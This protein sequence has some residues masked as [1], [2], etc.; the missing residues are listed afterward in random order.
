[1]ARVVPLTEQ[2]EAELPFMLAE[3]QAFVAAWPLTGAAIHQSDSTL[4]C[5]R[6]GLGGSKFLQLDTPPS[7]RRAKKICITVWPKLKVGF[8][9]FRWY[10]C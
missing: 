7:S 8:P 5:R 4:V 1:M 3:H 9:S 6:F 10:P 2:L